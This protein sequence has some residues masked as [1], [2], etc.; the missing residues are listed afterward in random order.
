MAPLT[1]PLALL[2]FATQVLGAPTFVPDYAGNVD[3]FGQRPQRC[4]LR[5]AF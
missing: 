2:A 5:V 1:S 4:W 3:N